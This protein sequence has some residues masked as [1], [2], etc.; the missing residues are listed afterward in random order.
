[1]TFEEYKKDK[2]KDFAVWA[3]G[4]VK[5]FLKKDEGVSFEDWEKGLRANADYYSV[6]R[7]TEIAKSQYGI[8]LTE[9]KAQEIRE[10]Y[11][12]KL[13]SS[14]KI[15]LTKFE[16]AKKVIAKYQPLIDEVQAL[17]D[18]IDLSDLHDGFPCGS[19]F[20]YL[21]LTHELGQALRQIRGGSGRSHWS[22]KIY[23]AKFPVDY[24]HHFQ[25][26]DFDRRI[27]DRVECFLR[28]RGLPAKTYSYID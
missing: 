23:D 27:S 5:S 3:N 18:S 20:V 16:K 8:A 26:I 1:M 19:A 10:L 15:Q 7:I 22:E 4:D 11:F 12:D 9:E 25:C 21:E 13:K 2:E 14:Y 28:D 17:V 6:K 24:R